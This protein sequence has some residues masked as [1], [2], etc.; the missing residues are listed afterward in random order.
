MINESM[1]EHVRETCIIMTIELPAI[2]KVVE[3]L[4]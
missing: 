2:Y 3:D 4:A 1:T